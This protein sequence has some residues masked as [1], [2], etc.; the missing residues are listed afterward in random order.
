MEILAVIP[1]RGGSKRLPGKNIKKLGKLPLIAHTILPALKSKYITK[2]VVTTDDLE[3]KKISQKYGAEVVDRPKELAGDL[4][5]MHEGIT[6]TL[7]YLKKTKN[8]SPDIIVLLQATVPLRILEDI[9]S[10]IKLFLE[11]KDCNCVCSVCEKNPYWSFKMEG[12]FAVPL[13]DEK[14]FLT[15]SQDLPKIYALNGAIYV[16][17]TKDF[18]KYKKFSLDKMIPYVM[19][20]D[21]SVDIDELRDFKLAEFYYKE[22]N[23]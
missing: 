11:N 20:D 22:K 7:D 4:S 16:L 23:V 14:Y 6:Y 21:R 2:V 1:A 12:K 5:L 9:D 8:Y 15:R 3:I 17:K 18:L 13:F 10:S 19:P